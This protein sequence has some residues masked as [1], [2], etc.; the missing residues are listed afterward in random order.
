MER[1]GTG[2]LIVVVGLSLILH[3]SMVTTSGVDDNHDY[4]DDVINAA[5]CR[6]RCLSLLQVSYVL[7]LLSQFAEN[8]SRDENYE[9]LSEQCLPS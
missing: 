5:R 6:V 2:R 4:S 3:D 1:F 8:I 9:K 7:R